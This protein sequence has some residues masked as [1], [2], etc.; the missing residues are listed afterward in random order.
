VAR[1]TL[2]FDAWTAGEVAPS[3]VLVPV[4]VIEVKD[5]KELRTTLRG[6]D[7]P[8]WQVAFSRDGKTLVSATTAGAIKLWDVTEERLRATLPRGAGD[9]YNLALTPDNATL[10]VAYYQF[11]RHAPS[12]TGE[13][14][15][16]D[17]ATGAEKA[18][19]KRD[20]AH[21]IARLAIAA[22]GRTLAAVEFWSED[23]GKTLKQAVVLWD[24]HA[25][26]AI[27]TL[28]EAGHP[29]G[30]AFSPDGKT[31]AVVSER[32]E[33][34]D[35]AARKER[36]ALKGNEMGLVSVV[37]SPDGK[38]LAGGEYQGTV[39]IW[40]AVTG[41][42]LARLLH[43]AGRRVSSL[44]FSPDSTTLAAALGSSE[45]NRIRPGT[46]VIWDVAAR[47]QRLL[48]H[49]HRHNVLSVSFNKDGKLLASGSSDHVIK[50]WNLAGETIGL[51]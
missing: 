42:P 45:P 34:F 13:I 5:S 46:I 48:L 51:K 22:D 28:P 24:L 44:A 29:N 19:L 35:I 16:W 3:R 11:D 25:G 37:F 14:K 26:K 50:L 9:V 17:V 1:V 36:A 30:L 2:S 41:T 31:L 18:T 21:G 20:Q 23:G 7:Q 40:N 38:L 8:L 15:L 6:H 33:L 47:R 39:Q 32:V 4:E 12:W 27:G 43:D 49:G 10:A